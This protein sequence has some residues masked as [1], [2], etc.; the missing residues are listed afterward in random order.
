[1]KRLASIAMVFMLA[2]TCGLAESWTGRLVDALCKASARD[3]DSP[4]PGCAAN[5]TTHL[6]AIELADA[7]L[8]ELDAAG[9]EKADDAIRNAQKTDLHVTVTG[10]LHGQTVKVATIKVQ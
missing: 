5:K 8:L 6:F 9:N 2:A 3:I 1:M 7:S 4:S 10:S